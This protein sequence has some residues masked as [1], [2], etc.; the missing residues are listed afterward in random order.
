MGDAIR[1]RK[2]FLLATAAL[3]ALAAHAMAADLPNKAPAYKA[4]PPP[5]FSWTGF[6]IGAHV[7]GGLVT[8]DFT[9]P[10]GGS[11]FGDSVR[12]PA[13]L[14]GGQVGYNWQAPG[15]NW[16]FG[17]QGDISALASDGDNTC[18]ALS[19]G[20]FNSTCRVRPEL[21]STL[22]AR[23]G[24]AF[25]P[26]GRT[27]IYVK[28]GAAWADSTIDLAINNAEFEIPPITANNATA[29][30]WG[31]T[32][33][34]GAEYALSA[35]WSLVFE[36][37]FFDFANA[38]VTTLGS[39]VLNPAGFITA[40]VPPGTSSVSA[41][42]QEFRLGLNYRWGADPTA[43]WDLVPAAPTAYLTKAPP[44]PAW[45]PGWE[46]EGGGR[47]FYSW[48]LFHKDIGPLQ[49]NPVPSPTSVSRLT[50]DDMQTNSGEF[51]ARIDSPW[52][53]FVKGFVGGGETDGGHMND[54]DFG[55]VLPGDIR[56]TSVAAPYSNTLA[57]NVTGNITYGVVDV[58]YDFLRAANYK[59][60]AFAGYA[61][62][63]QNMNA[64]GCTPIAN[65]NC[66]QAP[67]VSGVPLIT[68][69]DT[70]QGLRLG[71][72]GDVMVTDRVKLSG[73]AAY[74]PYVSFS[75]VD[76]HFFFN[77]G[78]LAEI[79]P[80]SSNGGQGVQLEA[81][82]S[83]YFTPQ[84][85]I[86]VGGRYWAMWTTD[87]SLFKSFPAPTPEAVFRGTFEQAGG[88]VQLAYRFGSP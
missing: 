72:A 30:T 36:Y 31:W 27:L 45:A 41:N 24:Y 59:V 85:S 11:I 10:F 6:Y 49:V 77:T 87:G 84:F 69:S 68:E 16:V 2:M 28:G 37:D 21:L 52:N 82:A 67:V 79:F 18:F 14:G 39:V 83:Y 8:T 19:A 51:F 38:N 17:L 70:W 35:A 62:F 61:Y 65:I 22:T 23:V 53:F 48:G 46:I 56:G 74:L 33:G 15:S 7:G 54:E 71:V 50:Y 3:V 63:K 55:I 43:S 9:N 32:V 80:E 64:F 42:I 73:D 81:V 78:G 88:F 44:A 25:G 66:T 1:V 5:V 86:G 13:F 75:G 57:S 4:P 20:T 40:V 26:S 12:S 29:S 34:A 76:N 47:Y 58:G 60:G